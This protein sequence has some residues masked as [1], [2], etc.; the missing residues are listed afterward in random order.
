MTS[1]VMAD[2]VRH[3]QERLRA[4]EEE[5]TLLS[6]S[7]RKAERERDEALAALANATSS[8]PPPPEPE[9][10]GAAPHAT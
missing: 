7:L 9:S 2:H 3:L 4:K 5:N 8:E 6:A 10:S 1:Q